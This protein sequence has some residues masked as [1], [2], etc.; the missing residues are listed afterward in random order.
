MAV[1]HIHSEDQRD[2]GT[3][4][5]G[6]LLALPEQCRIAGAVDTAKQSLPEQLGVFVLL[7]HP[8]RRYESRRRMEVKLT[9]LLLQRHAGHQIVYKSI[10]LRLWSAGCN[11]KSCKQDQNAVFH[12]VLC[13]FLSKAAKSSNVPFQ[14]LPYASLWIRYQIVYREGALNPPRLSF[15]MLFSEGRHTPY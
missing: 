2:A 15:M 9:D 3:G 8:L 7:R 14:L 10:H 6:N 11:D 12:R 4:F 5:Q 1:D 13:Y